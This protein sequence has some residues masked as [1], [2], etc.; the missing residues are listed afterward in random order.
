MLC[1]QKTTGK[2]PHQFQKTYHH[3]HHHH[4][5]VSSIVHHPPNIIY[6]LSSSIIYHQSSIINHHHLSS[7]IYHPSS[8]IYDDHH[9]IL[10]LKEPFCSFGSNLCCCP[11][12]DC[13]GGAIDLQEVVEIWLAIRRREDSQGFKWCEKKGTIHETSYVYLMFFCEIGAKLCIMSSCMTVHLLHFGILLAKFVWIWQ[14]SRNGWPVQ[15]SLLSCSARNWHGSNCGPGM[16]RNWACLSAKSPRNS[17]KADTDTYISICNYIYT[18]MYIYVQ[19]LKWNLWPT[20]TYK[21]HAV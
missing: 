15:E 11:W 18:Y 10:P 21:T 6:H 14:K 3:H 1:W 9:R 5:H 16:K 19:Y 7:F 12:L 13:L 17:L 4:P 8:I 20:K 2:I